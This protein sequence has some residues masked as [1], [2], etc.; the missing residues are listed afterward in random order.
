MKKCL[1]CS[2]GIPDHWK[3]CKDPICKEVRDTAQE[4]RA[5]ERYNKNYI[6]QFKEC[7]ICQDDTTKLWPQITCNKHSCKDKWQNRK[8]K[9]SKKTYTKYDKTVKYPR[10]KCVIC[11]RVLTFT[12]DGRSRTCSQQSC[13][14][15]WKERLRKKKRKKDRERAKEK[16]KLQLQ[17]KVNQ[18]VQELYDRNSEEY[19]DA[20]VYEK[21]QKEYLKFN[22]KFCRKC[23]KALW[24]NFYFRCPECAKVDTKGISDNDILPSTLSRKRNGRPNDA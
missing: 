24:G 5:K 17:S 2:N 7:P 18:Q 14:D 3:Y 21:D 16:R 9:Q 1:N 8:K 20:D 6:L 19:F 23:Q 13:K 10:R 12:E 4:I 22:G 15:K 11:R